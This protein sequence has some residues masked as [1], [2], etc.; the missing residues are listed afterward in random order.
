MD[1][2][3][4]LKSEHKAILKIFGEMAS[5]AKEESSVLKPLNELEK[6]LVIHLKKEDEILYP[7][8][9]QAEEEELKKLGQMFSEQM[10]LYTAE[11][12]GCLTEIKKANG[13]PD[14]ALL[15]RWEKISSR[16]ASRVNIEENIL[17]PAYDKYFG[18]TEI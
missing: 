12:I 1:F 17:F 18:K 11:V 5:L 2:I 15:A 4:T 13:Q 10:K 14:S 9:R 8:F 16:I 7:K 3:T 6:I